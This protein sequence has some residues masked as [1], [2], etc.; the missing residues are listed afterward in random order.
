MIK[1]G[2][3]G[4]I[5][6]GKS[7]VSQIFKLIGIPV[8][9]ADSESKQLITKDTNLKNA[10]IELLGSEI[11][12]NDGSLNRKLMA[13]K[14]FNDKELITKVNK[15]IHP[16]V[17]MDFISWTNAQSTDIVATE[18]ALLFESN[19]DKRLD[20]S[21][22]VYA[23]LDI[24]IERAMR[25]DNATREQIEARIKNQLSEE[26]KREMSDFVIINDGQKALLPQIEE[27]LLKIQ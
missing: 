9:D 6:S 24:R 20:Y 19:L 12:F 27:L 26:L 7:V 21:I 17:G 13:S 4:G 5:G 22:M 18:C 3:T 14:I 25:R 10:L 11:Y 1:L 16:A 8:Y 2:I 23:P 15:I